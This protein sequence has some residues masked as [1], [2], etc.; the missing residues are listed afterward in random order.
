MQDLGNG[1]RSAHADEEALHIARCDLQNCQRFGA[2]AQL[3]TTCKLQIAGDLESLGRNEEAV[4]IYEEVLAGP[5]MMCGL[6]SPAF[7][8]QLLCNVTIAYHKIGRYAD[9]MS[10]L[11][12]KGIEARKVFGPNHHVTLFIKRKYFD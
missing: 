12:G 9:A 10:L 2:S 5:A 1:L 7:V 3:L 11:E 6:L 8:L 4:E